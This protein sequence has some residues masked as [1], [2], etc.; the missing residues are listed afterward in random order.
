MA[1]VTVQNG[2]FAAAAGWTYSTPPWDINV[3]TPGKAHRSSSAGTAASKMKQQVSIGENVD[4]T[5]TVTI[6]NLS[7]GSII[8]YAS[9]YG[10]VAPDPRIYHAPMKPN[11]IEYGA[12]K[13]ALIQMV[14]YLAAHYGP[15]NVRVNA[16]APGPFP[17]PDVQRA[18][19]DFI[20]RLAA[21]NPLGRIGRRDE[22]A[23]AVVF[24]ASDG[25][26]YVTGQVLSV[27]GGWTAW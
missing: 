25:A 20:K 26:S 7:G 24:L 19:P 21:R 8:M 17:W 16:V 14:R 11:P 13:A 27:D 15:Q 18:E 4:Y 22:T 2:D 5:V 3:T 23:G 12:G 1:E 9:M 6:S 10:L